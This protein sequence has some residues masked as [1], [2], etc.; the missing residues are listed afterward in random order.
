MQLFLEPTLI[1]ISPMIIFGGSTAQLDRVFN[2]ADGFPE[3]EDLLGAAN[4]LLRLQDTYA[5]TAHDMARGQVP[6]A[7]LTA[8]MTG[9]RVIN[10]LFNLTR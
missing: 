9:N 8:N 6:G 7:S 5:L 10:Q 1:S 2:A 3:Q 4:A